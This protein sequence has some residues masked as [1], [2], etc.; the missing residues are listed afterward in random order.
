MPLALA[1]LRFPRGDE[2]S[3][4]LE[5]VILGPAER[6]MC[7]WVISKYFGDWVSTQVLKYK[8]MPMDEQGANHK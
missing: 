3:I 4:A 8:S 1:P 7:L 5:V 2:L 6:E